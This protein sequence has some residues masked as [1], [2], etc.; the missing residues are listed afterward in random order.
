MTS[1]FLDKILQACAPS[2]CGL[3]S[4]ISARALQSRQVACADGMLSLQTL[5]HKQIKTNFCSILLTKHEEFAETSYISENSAPPPFERTARRQRM[6][7]P[8]RAI[9]FEAQACAATLMHMLARSP[10]GAPNPVNRT[11]VGNRRKPPEARISSRYLASTRV[12]RYINARR[13]LLCEVSSMLCYVWYVTSRRLEHRGR[14][15]NARGAGRTRCICI[16]FASL[17]FRVRMR[18]CHWAIYKKRLASEI[19]NKI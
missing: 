3:L 6:P 19:K 12:S 16:P 17:T 4:N 15:R 14:P 1:I 2:M 9:L 10:S 8:G 7:P 11:N 5:P 18:D 13:P